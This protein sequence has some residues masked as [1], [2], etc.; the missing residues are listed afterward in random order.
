MSGKSRGRKRENGR[1]QEKAGGSR[2]QGQSGHDSTKTPPKNQQFSSIVAESP[3]NEEDSEWH[4][5][6]KPKSTL[7]KFSG[8]I[9]VFSIILKFNHNSRGFML[10]DVMEKPHASSSTASTTSREEESDDR[11]PIRCRAFGSVIKY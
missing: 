9:V 1:S 6:G 10:S 7:E 11:S 8:L 3:V 5:A 2:G 4:I